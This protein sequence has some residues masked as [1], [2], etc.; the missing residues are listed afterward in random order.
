MQKKDTVYILFL[1][2]VGFTFTYYWDC[3]QC[4]VGGVYLYYWA[5]RLPISDQLTGVLVSGF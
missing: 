2:T 3:L 1:L 4:N 5:L